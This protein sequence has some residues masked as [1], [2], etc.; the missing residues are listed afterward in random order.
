MV[1][2]AKKR[3]R[4]NVSEPLDLARIGRVLP[5]RDVSSHLITIGGIFRSI[6]LKVLCISTRCESRQPALAPDTHPIERYDIPVL[7]GRT[8]RNLIKFTTSSC[9]GARPF[10]SLTYYLSVGT[11]QGDEHSE[12]VQDRKHRLG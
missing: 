5:E 10:A 2:S 12:R 3:M 1:Q 11:H 8:E 9:L 4:N 7:P 6:P